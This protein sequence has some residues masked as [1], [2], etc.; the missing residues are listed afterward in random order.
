MDISRILKQQFLK[1]LIELGGH[2]CD[3]CKFR[4]LG[5]VV[6]PEW[7]YFQDQLQELS[8]EISLEKIG[9]WMVH[10]N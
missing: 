8:E 1:Q 10:V 7:D 4:G 2:S 9:A 3:A 6:K 5:R